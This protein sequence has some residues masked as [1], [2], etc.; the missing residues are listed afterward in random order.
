MRWKEWKAT[1]KT[2]SFI[3]LHVSP[4]NAKQQGRAKATGF[5]GILP[6]FKDKSSCAL[7]CGAT[8]SK[9]SKVIR[10][11][12]REGIKQMA[13]KDVSDIKVISEWN[14]AFDEDFLSIKLRWFADSARLASA[15]EK[16]EALALID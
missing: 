8:S 12:T 11:L 10:R 2:F 14:W 16:F 6:R 1:W 15:Y 5:S 4:Q 7:P 3:M 13:R 9:S